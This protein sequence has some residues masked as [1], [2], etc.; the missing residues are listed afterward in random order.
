MKALQDLSIFVRTVESGSLSATARELDITPA[1]ASAALKRLEQELHA[2]LFVRSTR[3]L[4]LTREGESFLVHC[5]I[6]LDALRDGVD[7]LAT[8]HQQIRGTL[9]IAA[10]SDLGRNV[11]LPW[12]DDF[13]KQHPD[14][15]FRLHLSDRMADLYRQPLDLAVRYGEPPDSSLIALSLAPGNRRVLCASPAY[16]AQY[17]A[18]Q[19]PQDL[20]DHDCLCFMTG[21]GDSELHDRWTFQRG[22]E[23][24]TVRVRG[25]HVSNDGDIVRRWAIAGQGIAFKSHLDIAQD[26]AEGR[27]RQLCPDWQGEASPLYLMC[28]D[29]RLL[30]PSVSLLRDFVETRCAALIA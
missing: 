9:Q 5:R 4:R 21:V 30:S 26:L 22:E 17:P 8:G 2:P 10:P 7:E 19:S 27:L 20:K 28:A 3:S 12:L 14:I 16:L 13:H 24:L 11:L 18:L 1:A 29:R 23:S 25:G 6:A 15:R